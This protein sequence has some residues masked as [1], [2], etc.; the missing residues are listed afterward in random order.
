LSFLKNKKRITFLVKFLVTTSFIYWSI[1]GE[2]IDFENIKLGLTNYK[3]GVIFL[4]LTFLQ[5]CLGSY[6]SLILLQLK[7]DSFE[8]FKNITKITWASSFVHCV[9][10]VSLISDVYRIKQLMY[11]E[12]NHVKDNSIY[13]SIY[14]KIFSIFALIAISCVSFLFLEKVPEQISFFRWVI[15]FSLL[16]IVLSVIFKEIIIIL[17][18]K[19]INFFYRFSQA[20]FYRER[21][22]NFRLYNR[23]MMSEKARVTLVFGL[24]VMLQLLNSISILLITYTLNPQVDL[25]VVELLCVIPIGIFI[26][27]LPISFSG[28]GV[29]HLAFS[30]LLQFFSISNGADIFSVFFAFS[31]IFNLLGVIPFMGILKSELKDNNEPA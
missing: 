21:I 10:P 27:T 22:D 9:S 25:S 15:Y 6:R 26:M 12:K 28:L 24:T 30:K 13:T 16:G 29:G 3:L 1:S 20:N 7:E 4:G 5:L 31:L 14:S 8:N 23:N 11:V 2:K 19:M 18:K 17:L